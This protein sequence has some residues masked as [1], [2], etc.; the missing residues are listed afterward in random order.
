MSRMRSILKD[1]D[2][3]CRR[4]TA[5]HKKTLSI[6]L[7]RIDNSQYDPFCCG[8]SILKIVISPLRS[9]TCIIYQLEADSNTLFNGIKDQ[10]R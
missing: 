1:S 3:Q 7:L 5:R 10:Y 4:D 8:R 6:H 9:H 2:S